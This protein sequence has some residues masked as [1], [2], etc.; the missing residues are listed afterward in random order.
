MHMA[1][2]NV[3]ETNRDHNIKAFYGSTLQMEVIAKEKKG[4]D[5]FT[6]VL[7]HTHP[8]WNGTTFRVTSEGRCMVSRTKEAFHFV[9]KI[10]CDKE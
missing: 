9:R 3:Y 2:G 1:V 5:P 10:D 4:S 8:R 6:V 7:H